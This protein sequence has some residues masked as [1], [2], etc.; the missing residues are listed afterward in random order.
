MA[1]AKIREAEDHIKQAEKYLKTSMF[2]WNPDYDSAGDCYSRAATAYKVGGNKEKAVESLDKACNCYKEIRT[3]FQAARML[4]QA[5]L[6]SR[7]MNKM[8]DVVQYAER[9]ALLFRQDGSNETASQL[10]EKAAKIVEGSTPEKAIGLYEKASET[11]GVEDR[12]REAADYLSR[13]ARLQVRCKM[14][15]ESVEN[16]QKSLNIYLGI[17]GN[18]AAAGRSAAGLVMVQLMRDA[19][20][21]VIDSKAVKNLD[22]DFARLAKQIK[23]PDSDA[24]DAA[25]AKLGAERSAVVE[26]EK[27]AAAKQRAEASSAMPPEDVVEEQKKLEESDEDDL[28]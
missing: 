19:A 6:L 8:D 4:D 18:N 23:L 12:P 20:K 10:L 22:I 2:K 25:A 26:K 21:E 5:V 13:A 15:E 1:N 3:L 28:C 17:G 24:F 16:L 7:D 11:V 9:G 27:R 14:Y